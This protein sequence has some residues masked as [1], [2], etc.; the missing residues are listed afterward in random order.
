MFVLQSVAPIFVSSIFIRM[1]FGKEG[2]A[3]SCH[4]HNCSG[5]FGLLDHVSR[6]WTLLIKNRSC[7]L[8]VNHDVVARKE[9]YLV[10]L[11]CFCKKI[12][13]S[14]IKHWFLIPDKSVST[15]TS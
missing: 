13:L 3:I 4:E 12:I 1:K 2:E 15:D 5:F 10:S 8:M 9:F 11:W 6:C 7:G 14:G